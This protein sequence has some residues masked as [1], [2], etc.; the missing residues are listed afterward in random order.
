MSKYT[1]A[2]RFSYESELLRVISARLGA[3]PLIDHSRSGNLL[4]ARRQELLGEA[5]RVTAD[6]LP[7]THAVYRS[8]LELLGG[9]LTGDLFVQQSGV[10][11]AS[12]F[13]HDTQFDILVH[14]ALLKDFTADELRFVFGHE[15]GHVFFKH[16]L[17]PVR[18]IIEQIGE[19]SPE[20][21]ALLLRWSR[22]SEISA[23]RMGM[24]C[25]GQ[26][27]PAVSALFKTASGLSGIDMG[28][29]LTSFRKQYKALESQIRSV[30]EVAGWVRTH[31]M[32]PIR[33]KALEL[34]ALDIIALGRRD[35]FFSPRG[36]R[37]IDR[38][39]ADLLGALDRMAKG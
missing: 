30:G 27:E 18:G 14:S 36:F 3:V 26:L 24:L 12:V 22:A 38:Q 5:V 39:V 7:E 6:L 19:D 31:P 20:A 8:C 28:R 23:D 16:S 29:V 10:Y 2:L 1:E 35:G 13:A 33:F 37:D 25:C 4:A 15:L 34:A 21:V 9:G 11:N 17:F 32:V